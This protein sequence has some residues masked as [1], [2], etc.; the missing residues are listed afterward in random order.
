MFTLKKFIVFFFILPVLIVSGQ[1]IND[2]KNPVMVLGTFHFSYPNLDMIK[3]EKKDQIDVM[4]AERQKEIL[5]MVEQ[6]KKFKPT[7]V[8]L[9]IKT[10]AQSRI[11]SQ[12]NAYLEGTFTL[13]KDEGYQVGFRLAKALGHKKVYCIDEWG[14]IDYFFSTTDG[15]NFNVRTEREQQMNKYDA[16]EDSLLKS[17]YFEKKK[18]KMTQQAGYMS[19]QQVLAGINKPGN[20]KADHAGYFDLKFRFEATP[21]DYT[22]ADWVALTWYSRNLR[23]FRNIQRIT[24]GTGDRI[25]VLYGAGHAYLLNQFVVESG[26]YKLESPLPYLKNK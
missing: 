9:E 2:Q 11:D 8:A 18:L 19:L 13:P 20:L 17:G 25:F 14:N 22:G 16:F 10:S 15:K 24:E 4:T 26:N 1:D 3:T 21:Y 12:Y 23:I 5:A 6:L 7:K